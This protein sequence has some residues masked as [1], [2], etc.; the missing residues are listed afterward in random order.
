MFFHLNTEEKNSQH[1]RCRITMCG[2]GGG[3]VQDM[4]SRIQLIP[5]ESAKDLVQQR[6]V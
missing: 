4:M 3:V 2:T 6:K 5:G 1:A